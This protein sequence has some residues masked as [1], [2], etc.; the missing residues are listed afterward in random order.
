MDYRRKIRVSVVAISCL[1]V[2]IILLQGNGV[3]IGRHENQNDIRSEVGLWT[4]GTKIEQT[5]IASQ[6]KLCRIDFFVKSY[7]PWDNP[8]LDCRLFEINTAENP[9]DLSY[10]F[11][12]KNIKEVRYKR[13]NGWLISGHMPNSFSF[14]PIADSQNKRYFLSIQSPGLKRGGTGILLTSPR[15]RY[16]QGNLFENGEKQERDL[17]FRTLYE[18][19]RT[20][21][22][23]QSFARLALQKPC[24]F[25]TSAS[26][27]VL[28][29][30]YIVLLLMFLYRL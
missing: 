25:S 26:F 14:A 21:L 27:Y 19:P 10:E 28:F 18:E 6:N 12:T 1:I 7:H 24:L 16:E 9:S 23:Q 8:Y 2:G 4:S 29:G 3:V 20:Q 17:G 11:I 30:V 13:I 15:E 5:F 22:I